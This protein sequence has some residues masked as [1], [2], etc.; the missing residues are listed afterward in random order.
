MDQG[1]PGVTAL[2]IYQVR[3]DL[4]KGPVTRVDLKDGKLVPP[5]RDTASILDGQRKR[6]PGL[7]DAALVDAADGWSNGWIVIRKVAAEAIDGSL[8]I[9]V[10]RLPHVP[11]PRA[12]LLHHHAASKLLIGELPAFWRPC[13]GHLMNC[14]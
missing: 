11:P 6:H 2:E 8:H 3:G 10:A 13:G 1:T 5:D 7:S 14:S 9:L 4:T 12:A